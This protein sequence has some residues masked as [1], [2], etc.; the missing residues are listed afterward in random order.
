M[1]IPDMYVNGTLIRLGSTTYSEINELYESLGYHLDKITGLEYRATEEG[2]NFGVDMK[3]IGPNKGEKIIIEVVTDKAPD[4]S[5]IAKEFGDD[6]GELKKEQDDDIIED[7]WFLKNAYIAESL[8]KK[9]VDDDLSEYVVTRLATGKSLQSDDIDLLFAIG[10]TYKDFADYY[11]DD[12]T[13]A[14][15][16]IQYYI[17]NPSGWYY[18]ITIRNNDN[19]TTPSDVMSEVPVRSVDFRIHPITEGLYAL[20]E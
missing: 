7:G 1:P 8:D 6:E 4:L 3:Y 5:V 2:K 18:E 11:G 14:S 17:K 20:N 19:Q 10:D 16:Y 15:G 9:D 13:E 12:R